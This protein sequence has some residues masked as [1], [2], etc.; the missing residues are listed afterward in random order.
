MAAV[1]DARIICILRGKSAKFV[2]LLSGVV[3]EFLVAGA[4]QSTQ[5]WV[6]SIT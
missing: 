1:A 3:K 5:L 2:K 6:S 4:A